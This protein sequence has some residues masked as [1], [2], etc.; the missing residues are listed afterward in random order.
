MSCPELTGASLGVS[1]LPS[2]S[3][4]KEPTGRVPPSQIMPSCFPGS[5][6]AQKGPR[7]GHREIPDGET[8]AISLY[9][10]GGMEPKG[11][12]TLENI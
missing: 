10:F 5:S 2:C 11:L 7:E 8:P 9:L 12:P 6:P 1:T 3:S 4:L